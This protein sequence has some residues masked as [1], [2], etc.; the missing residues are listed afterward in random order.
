MPV[1]DTKRQSDELRQ[2]CRAT[3][4][5]L[6]HIITPGCRAQLLLS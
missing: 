4:P 1:V 3:R 6:D 5:G 2:N